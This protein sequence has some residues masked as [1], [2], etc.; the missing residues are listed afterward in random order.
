MMSVAAPSRPTR[1]TPPRRCM[2][3][4]M[5]GSRDRLCRSVRSCICAVCANTEHRRHNVV[6]VSTAAPSKKVKSEKHQSG[7]VEGLCMSSAQ[8]TKS[9]ITL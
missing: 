4:C 8:T 5:G 9:A 1:Q 2:G 7:E 6:S 3:D